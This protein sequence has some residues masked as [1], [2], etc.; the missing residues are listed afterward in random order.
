MTCRIEWIQL[1]SSYIIV[2]N[3]YK[4]GL[5]SQLIWPLAIC[6]SHWKLQKIV[7]ALKRE[8]K[9][10]D[11]YWNKIWLS[12]Q[13][14][15]NSIWSILTIKKFTLLSPDAECFS[16]FGLLDRQIAQSRRQ[17]NK[18]RLSFTFEFQT[19]FFSKYRRNIL[20]LIQ[21]LDDHAISNKN[22]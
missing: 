9:T 19:A 5:V 10:R 11:V 20:N 14:V 17:L 1:W 16:N 7:D 15:S 8:R 4:I 12:T 6:R 21:H 2:V 3:L 18:L 13:L 22:Q